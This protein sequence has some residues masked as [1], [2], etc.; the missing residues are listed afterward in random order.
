MGT[1][2]KHE[3]R[4]FWITMYDKVNDLI[5]HPPQY[6]SEINQGSKALQKYKD[7]NDR[8]GEQAS[9]LRSDRRS[10]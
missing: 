1:N 10:C 4:K 6:H 5:F 8:D 9:Q 3:K 7:Q 2:L